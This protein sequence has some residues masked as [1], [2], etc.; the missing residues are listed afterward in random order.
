MISDFAKKLKQDEINH[1]KDQDDK[2]TD[3]F[4]KK[5]DYNR[6]LAGQLIEKTNRRNPVLMNTHE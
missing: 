5:K 2:K 4:E 1:K 6:I 3:I